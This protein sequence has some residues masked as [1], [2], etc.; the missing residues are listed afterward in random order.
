MD[1]FERVLARGLR[2]ERAARGVA[3]AVPVRRGLSLARWC[4]A[5]A[6]LAAAGLVLSLGYAAAAQVLPS[7]VNVLSALVWAPIGAVGLIVLMVVRE[8]LRAL[9]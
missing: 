9:R 7:A 3:F 1:E 5:L 8:A 6:V 2:A 4:A